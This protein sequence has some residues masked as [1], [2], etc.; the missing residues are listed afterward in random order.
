MWG[1]PRNR[2]HSAKVPQDCEIPGGVIVTARPVG[3]L[4]TPRRTP[5]GASTA[6]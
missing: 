4:Q 2:Q 6:R 5:L 1:H 3:D